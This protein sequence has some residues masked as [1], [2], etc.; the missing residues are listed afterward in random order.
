MTT[1]ESIILSAAARAKIRTSAELARRSG[2]PE[3]TMRDKMNHPEKIRL[4]DLAAWNRHISITDQE[5]GAMV[6][7]CK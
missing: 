4:S 5:L 7:M 3:S 2:T 6:R 1:V